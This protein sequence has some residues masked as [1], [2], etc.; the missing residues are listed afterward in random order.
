MWDM[1][2][3]EQPEGCEWDVEGGEM[4][5]LEDLFRGVLAWEPEGR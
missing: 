5:V 4:R 3:G 1:G 2:P